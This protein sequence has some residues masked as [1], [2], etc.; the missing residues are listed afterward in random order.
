ML[1]LVLLQMLPVVCTVVTSI[2][3]KYVSLMFFYMYSEL[4]F[5]TKPFATVLGHALKGW[6]LMVYYFVSFQ[7]TLKMG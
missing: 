1:E 2:T 7:F 5:M 4:P 3:F 6:I